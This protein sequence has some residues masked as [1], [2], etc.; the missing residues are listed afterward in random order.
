MNKVINNKIKETN[1]ANED[2]LFEA[3][4]DEVPKKSMERL[5]EL[6][7]LAMDAE[8]NDNWELALKQ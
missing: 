3:P 5:K 1:D 6:L 4:Y 8:A 2:P 7:M